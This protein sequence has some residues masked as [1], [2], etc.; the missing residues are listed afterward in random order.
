MSLLNLFEVLIF[1]SV[2]PSDLSAPAPGPRISPEEDKYLTYSEDDVQSATNFFVDDVINM[3]RDS[4]G[5]KLDPL[6]IPNQR[7]SFERTFISMKIRGKYISRR[8]FALS[9]Q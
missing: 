6:K 5:R 9:T 7:F 4:W 1:L 8:Y 3:F 2:I